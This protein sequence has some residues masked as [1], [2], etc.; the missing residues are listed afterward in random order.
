M[1]GATAALC[2]KTAAFL[3]SQLLEHSYSNKHLISLD[4][5][6]FQYFPI[7]YLFPYY[8]RR[9]TNFS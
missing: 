2:V 6:W 5:A 1:R 3:V 7:A 4:L 9:F 8:N